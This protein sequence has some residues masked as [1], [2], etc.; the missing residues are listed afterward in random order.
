[1]RLNRFDFSR[2]H[3]LESVDAILAR[4]GTDRL[5]ILLLHRPDPLWEGEEIAEA[6]QKLRLAGK[7]RYFGFPTRAGSKSNIS[8]PFCQNPWWRTRWR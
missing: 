7:V 1:L 4:L 5:E 8:S 6:F 2:E 3:I